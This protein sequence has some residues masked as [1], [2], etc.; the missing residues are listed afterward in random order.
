MDPAAEDRLPQGQPADLRTYRVEARQQYRLGRVVDDQVDSG[1]RLEGADVAPLAA[2]DPA[3]HLVAGQVQDAD[4]ALGGLLAGHPL[5]RVDH[6]VPGALLTGRPGL[7]LDLPYQQ[8]RFPLGLR[9]DRLDQLE[10]GGIGGP[11]PRAPPLPAPVLLKLGGQRLAGT[12]RPPA[13]APVD[14]PTADPAG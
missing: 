6:D 7:V 11:P 13:P 2:D 8:R 9:L 10:P 1:H 14:L 12:Q 4:H 5:D 3:L